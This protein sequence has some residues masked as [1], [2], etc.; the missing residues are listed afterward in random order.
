MIELLILYILNGREKTVYGIRREI[1][2][3]FGA[4]TKPSLGT[5]HPALK[6]LLVRD[7]VKFEKK[8]SEG[9]KK[10]TYYSITDQGKSIF[11]E[12]FFEPV[13]ENPT[14]FHAQLSARLLTI[15]LL[16]DSDKKAFLSELEQRTEIFKAGIENAL[17][18]PYASYDEWQKAVISGTLENVEALSALIGR[19]KTY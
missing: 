5:V 15:S 8:Y 14:L 1:V 6:R 2:E 11:K 16:E 9:G 10:S 3:K 17:K 7:A 4:V 12:L 19:L 13:S 18:N